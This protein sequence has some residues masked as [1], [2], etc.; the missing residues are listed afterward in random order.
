MKTYIL[1]LAAAEVV[2]LL[3]A[4]TEAAHGAPELDIGAPEREYVIEENFDREAYG[5]HDGEQFDLVTSITTLTIE[6]RVES[7]YWI[8]ETVIERPLGPIP[9][10]Q[11][12]ELVRKN[13][14]LD[15]FEAELWAPGQKRVAVRLHVQTSTV[16]HDFDRWLTDMRARHPWKAETAPPLAHMEQKS[17]AGPMSK[18]AENGEKI[19]EAV[20]VFRDPEALEAAVDELEVS[21]FDRAA[22]SVLATDSKATEQ[23]ERFYRTVRDIED[24]GSVPRGVFVSCDSRTEGK[25]AVVGFPI[26]VGGCAGAAAVVA[27][28]GALALAIA[29]AL[30]G[31]AAGAGLGA[32]FAAAIARHYTTDMQQ[33]LDKG[34]L[35]LWV[36]A[37]D[38]DAEKRAVAIL[39]KMGAQDVH[40]HEIKPEW[41]RVPSSVVQAD[42]FLLEGDRP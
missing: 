12:D 4:E 7:G 29:G 23:I 34:G 26:Y 13:P 1:G 25:A 5:L 24:S 33:Q 14:T 36:H 17:G 42:P 8:L 2:H 3:R 37:P 30:I 40:V 21:G 31:S 20:G 28:G 19:K 39:N 11:E 9:T 41:D 15:D 32:I 16:K 18:T 6:P 10:A 38:A 35:V 27:A 22:I